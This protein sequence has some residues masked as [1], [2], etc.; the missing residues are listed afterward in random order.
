MKFIILHGSFGS[1]EGGWFP[2]LKEKL[3]LLKQ[4][5]V[6]LQFPIDNWSELTEQRDKYSK[7]IQ[8]LSNWLNFFEQKILPRIKPDD[9]ICVVAHSLGPLF[10][11]HA[12]S[13]FDIK[14]DSAIFISPFFDVPFSEKNWQIDYVNKSFYFQNFN[15]KLLRERMP[16]SYVLYSDNDP[17]VPKE[18]S[19]LFGEKLQSS[20]I[21]VR[22]AGHMNSEVDLIEFPLVYELCKTRL[23]LSWYQKFTDHRKEIFAI[24]YINRNTEEVIYLKPKEVEQEGVFKFRNLKHSGFCTLFTKIKLWNTQSKY[25]E[26]NRNAAK[27][28]NNMI[29][30]MLIYKENDLKKQVVLDQ[31]K[32]DL[33]AGIQ[34]YICQ[35]KD[36]KSKMKEYDFGLWDE[37]Y[38]C[39][40]HD[41]EV[42]LSS[43]KKDITEAKKWKAIVMKHAVKI[44]NYADIEQY[45]KKIKE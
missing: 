7:N 39:V 20:T 13:Q 10:F 40:V 27:R 37:E 2:E 24:D 29:R 19:I 1:P 14:L 25:M 23:D 4:D 22:K 5:V 8:T 41:D 34:V 11:L 38:L 32:K 12:L 30:V 31:I 17:Y 33:N 26:E 45:Q 18:G 43:R 6:S 36:V 3:I 16:I 9:K 42:K 21:L 15:F 28:I 44:N 35:Y